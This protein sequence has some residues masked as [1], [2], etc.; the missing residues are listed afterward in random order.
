MQ[1]QLGKRLYK[2]NQSQA[3][4]NPE[5]YIWVI[6]KGYFERPRLYKPFELR[7]L[8]ESILAEEAGEI[9]VPFILSDEVIVKIKSMVKDVVYHYA[10][11][12]HFLEKKDL[13]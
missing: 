1:Q 10:I 13:F 8:F 2:I 7:I 5:K 9:E 12:M 11:K 4:S 3:L 6:G